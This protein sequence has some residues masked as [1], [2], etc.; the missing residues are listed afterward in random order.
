MATVHLVCGFLGSGKTTFAKS[1]AV[2]ESA[3]RL[4]VDELYLRLFANGPTYELDQQSLDRLLQVLNDLWPQI[5]QTGVSVVLDFGFW[6]RSLRDEVR[7]RA[8]SAGARVQLYWLQCADDVAI[9]RCLQRNGQPDSFMISAQGFHELK[10]LFQPPAFD[11][12]CEIVNSG[13]NVVAGSR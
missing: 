10:R 7:D 9:A 11:E 5:V 8:R 13:A 6:N 3:L 12:S 4:S 1:L 2:K